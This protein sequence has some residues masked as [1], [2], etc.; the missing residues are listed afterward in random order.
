MA[1]T[2]VPL[3]ALLL[4]RSMAPSLYALALGIIASL[5]AFLLPLLARR[6]PPHMGMLVLGTLLAVPALD[7]GIH[8]RQMAWFDGAH[9]LPTMAL[10]LTLQLAAGVGRSAGPLLVS[11]G[12]LLVALGLAGGGAR[13]GSPPGPAP[14]WRR[15]A[16]TA[17]KVL[18]ASWMV[19]G[20]SAWGASVLLERR[21]I[22]LVTPWSGDPTVAADAVFLA[23][24]GAFAVVCLSGLLS[25]VAW[26][27]DRNPVAVL[28]PCLALLGCLQVHPPVG[29]MLDALPS[30]APPQGTEAQLP[31]AAGPGFAVPS[32]PWRPD[33]TA[34][35][36]G[37]TRMGL[38]D[39]P[40]TVPGPWHANETPWARLP[41]LT[42]VLAL[43]AQTSDQDLASYLSILAD[44]EVRQVGLV[45][46]TPTPAPPGPLGDRLAWPQALFLLDPPRAQDVVPP[47]CRMRVQDH[48]TLQDLVSRWEAVRPGC[49][50][51]M[52]LAF[53][54]EEAT[55]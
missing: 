53:Q 24:A 31:M 4:G 28:V 25:L 42:A 21:S 7:A 18:A 33:P 55:P 41:R 9:L 49:T 14:F 34:L 43:P 1:L 36:L 20:A 26:R 19:A 22:L 37:L 46:R 50:G 17:W 54:A 40:G 51:G 30:S 47:L 44:H 12:L 10:N 48:P 15:P 35:A 3:E 5:S 29:A 11:A 45:L 2:L 16:P 39:R 23:G 27:V 8:A 32:R 52:G 38:K 6:F 13:V